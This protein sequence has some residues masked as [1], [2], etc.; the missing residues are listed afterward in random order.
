MTSEE[1]KSNENS[2]EDKGGNG[3]SMKQSLQT[4]IENT[5]NKESIE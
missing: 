3:S 1:N 2:N 4:V 5:N